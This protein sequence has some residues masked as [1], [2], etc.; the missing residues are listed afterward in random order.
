MRAFWVLSVLLGFS[1]AQTLTY[2]EAMASAERQAGVVQAR[3][4]LELAQQGWKRVANDPLTLRIDRTQAEQRLALAERSL[5]QAQRQARSDI[6]EAYTQALDAQQG[7]E[8]ARA[9]MLLAEQ[10]VD[11]TRIRLQ[12][13]TATNLNLAEATN[14]LNDARTRFASTSS[15]LLLARSNLQ[16]L[17]GPYSQLAPVP[18]SAIIAPPPRGET[19]KVLQ[20]SPTLLQLD[21]AVELATI[22]L[23][24]LDPS[25]APQ[26]TIEDTQLQLEQAQEARED[27]YRLFNLGTESLYDQ[28]INA[29]RNREV[30]EDTFRTTRAQLEISRQRFQAGLDSEI[31]YRQSVFTTLQAELNAQMARHDYLRAVWAFIAG[32]SSGASGPSGPQGTPEAMPA[33][34]Q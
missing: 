13:G 25:Y 4:E 7:L 24:S 10:V 12:T 29:A 34:A 31:T 2:P 18:D 21:Q 8:V 23:N 11:I 28:V 15:G 5:D 32:P 1:L 33:G 19:A 3:L 9:G 20:R 16:G 17:V 22:G 27:V 26:A 6:T 30:Q 14:Q